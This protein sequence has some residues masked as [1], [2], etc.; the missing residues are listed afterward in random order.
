MF[1]NALINH[2]FRPFITNIPCYIELS[3]L[4]RQNH[5]PIQT[6]QHTCILLFKNY[7]LNFEISQISKLKT[8]RD[9][10]SNSHEVARRWIPSDH[11]NDK[12]TLVHVM[13][14]SHYLRQNLSTSMSQYGVTRP[15]CDNHDNIVCRKLLSLRHMIKQANIKIAKEHFICQCISHLHISMA[16]GKT[17]V[18]PSLTHW[19][20]HSLALSHHFL[21]AWRSTTFLLCTVI[22][23]GHQSMVV[24]MVRL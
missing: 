8:R 23:V 18:T 2:W 12:S 16:S 5:F 1:L 7:I 21:Q 15:Q 3:P 14:P 11:T 9:T 6:T 10:F 20:C 24:C 4:E 22:D 13:A 19:S 17:A